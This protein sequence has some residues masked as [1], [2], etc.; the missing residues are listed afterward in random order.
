MK[1]P[2]VAAAAM[3]AL[4]L[5]FGLAALASTAVGDHKV[6]ITKTGFAPVSL[7]IKA[8]D[9]VVW[10]N[11][12]DKDHTV[13]SNEKVPGEAQD[14]PMFDSG[15]LKPGATWEFTFPKPGKYAYHCTKDETMTGTVTVK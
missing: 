15:P 10:T 9:K 11:A 2:R 13:T 3:A 8:G 1:I 4:V 5:A 12:D 7:Q 14:R 6:E